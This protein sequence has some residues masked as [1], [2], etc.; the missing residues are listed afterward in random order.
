MK[1]NGI[2]PM[3][4]QYFEIKKEYPDAILF[5]RM[6][7]FYEMFFDDARVAA[8]ILEVVLTSRNKNKGDAVPLCGV[9]YHAMENYAAK[10]LARASRWPSANRSKTRPWPRGSCGAKSPICSPRPPLW[11]SRVWSRARATYIV[12][13]A[14]DDT[15]LA[16]AALDLAVS[17]FEVKSFPRTNLEGFLNELFRKCPREIVLA[18]PFEAELRSLE[19]RLPDFAPILVTV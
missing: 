1:E 17:D 12:S 16:L 14:V 6:G 2:T 18:K 8:P 15:S 9:P 7:D 10:L 13:L 4:K 11:K 5:F 19:K 3:L